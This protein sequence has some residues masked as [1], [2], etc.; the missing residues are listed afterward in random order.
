MRLWT[1][2][3]GMGGITDPG[4]GYKLHLCGFQCQDSSRTP[5]IASLTVHTC[6]VPTSRI[7]PIFCSNTCDSDSKTCMLIPAEIY[8][9]MDLAPGSA[10]QRAHLKIR[11]VIGGFQC[12]WSRF[13]NQNLRE[14]LKP[15]DF[16]FLSPSC[17]LV[18]INIVIAFSGDS[19][20][21]CTLV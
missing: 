16:F 6:P 11:L 15:A 21:L 1:T 9:Y 4:V 12:W 13:L 3:S 19:V 7:Q 14:L 17:H 8:S 5:W 2:P 18:E 20:T 10:F